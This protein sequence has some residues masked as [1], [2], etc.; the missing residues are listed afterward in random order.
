MVS[1]LLPMVDSLRAFDRFIVTSSLYRCE[2]ILKKLNRF[3]ISRFQFQTFH[4]LSPYH[5]HQPAGGGL[6]GLP[7]QSAKA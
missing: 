4:L 6:L 3:L 1:L 7:R 2:M 5:G